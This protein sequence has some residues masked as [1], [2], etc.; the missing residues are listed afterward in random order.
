MARR[1]SR[2][3]VSN[4][5]L[6]ATLLVIGVA[7]LALGIL[8]F[9]TDKIIA[10]IALILIPI[11]LIG[12][13]LFY[14][15][16]RKLQIR[17]NALRELQIIDL[18]NMS[19]IAFE[20][21]IAQLFRDEGYKVEETPRSGD[22]GVDFILAKAGF[23]TAL[24]CKRYSKPVSQEA[25]REAVTGMKHYRCQRSMVVTNNSFTK[26]ARDL[27]H[28]NNCTLIDREALIKMISRRQANYQK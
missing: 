2:K 19:G 27:A 6:F 1:R 14:F 9:P 20:E 8:Q 23:R 15:S 5:E 22:Y 17:K 28:S 16:Y 26:H 21:Y 18:D 11:L 7:L 13:G 25:I 4:R 3:Q 10:A 12:A 24:Q